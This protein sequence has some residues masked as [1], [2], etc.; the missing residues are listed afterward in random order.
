MKEEAA[1]IFYAV[2]FFGKKTQLPQHVIPGD[3]AR[4]RRRWIGTTRTREAPSTAGGS[5][6]PTRSLRSALELVCRPSLFDGKRLNFEW[7]SC[8]KNY[9]HSHFLTPRFLARAPHGDSL[10]MLLAP[11]TDTSRVAAICPTSAIVRSPQPV[12]ENLWELHPNALSSSDV[13]LRPWVSHISL[14][15]ISFFVNRG[16]GIS[17]SIFFNLT[18]KTHVLFESALRFLFRYF[19]LLLPSLGPAPLS[20]HSQIVTERLRI[21]VQVKASKF[22]KKHF[23]GKISS[24]LITAKFSSI[25]WKNVS[26]IISLPIITGGH[27]K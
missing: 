15:P 8:R 13:P 12:V 25:F 27:S 3:S 2:Q 21:F 7:D 5:R 22:P 19:S 6:G 1:S 9:R 14:A 16:I 10:P 24:P 4:Q 18:N 23:F 11:F 17:T 26:E 20:V